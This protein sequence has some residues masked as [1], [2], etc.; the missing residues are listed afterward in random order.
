MAKIIIGEAQPERVALEAGKYRATITRASD[1]IVESGK[2]SGA[3]KVDITL[4]TE[5]GGTVRDMFPITTSMAWKINQICHA[6]RLGKEGEE[7]NFNAETLLGKECNITVTRKEITK[8]DGTSMKISQ[9][10]RYEKIS[11]TLSIDD[12]ETPF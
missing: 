3:D 12:E 8:V 1:G 10:A 2:N 7:L 9:V 6:L 4:T 5:T 11:P